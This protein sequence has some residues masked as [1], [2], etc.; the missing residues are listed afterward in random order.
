M[1]LL[2]PSQGTAFPTPAPGG[3]PLPDPPTP[4]VHDHTAGK[5]PLEKTHLPAAG[6]PL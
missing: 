2:P 1:A 6:A 5:A 4:S 3:L